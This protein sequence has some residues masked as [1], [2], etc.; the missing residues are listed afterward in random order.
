MNQ[1][2]EIGSLWKGKILLKVD[3]DPDASG[4]KTLV[5]PS[6]NNLVIEAL[7]YIKAN[8]RAWIIEVTVFEAYFLPGNKKYRIKVCCENNVVQTAEIVIS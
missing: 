6:D 8:K 7:N 3:Y 5:A 4:P 1:N 2:P